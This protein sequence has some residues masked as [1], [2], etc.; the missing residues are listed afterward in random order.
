M[1]FSYCFIKISR[2]ADKGITVNAYCPGI[3][4]T[5]M[6]NGIAEQTAKEADES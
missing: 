6:M 4:K 1:K 2:L 3:V 5:P